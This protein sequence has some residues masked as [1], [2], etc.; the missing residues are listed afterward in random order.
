MSDG[1]DPGGLYDGRCLH[2]GGALKR[3]QAKYCCF[4]CAQIGR[5]RSTAKRRGDLL[6][7]RG[8]GRGYVKREGVHEHRLVAEAMLGRSLRPDEVVHHLNGDLQDNRSENL[9]VLS[10][11]SEHMDRHREALLAGRSDIPS[12]EI[13]EE[14]RAAYSR[15]GVTH[16]ELSGRYGISLVTI[17]RIIRRKNLDE[18]E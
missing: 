11:Q 12:R 8:E 3:S 9:E 4:P 16:N 7:G 6:R 14:V 10:S 1:S 5:S 18:R 13:R 17:G 2:C 15:G